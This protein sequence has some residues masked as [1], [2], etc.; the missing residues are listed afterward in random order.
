MLVCFTFAAKPGMEKEFEAALND[1]QMGRT[2]ARFL[3][4]TRNTLF[5]GHG[6][7]V[8]ILEFPDDH[9]VPSLADLAKEDP[10]FAAFMRRLGSL[11]QDGFDM[12]KPETLAAFNAR[13]GL[14]VVFDVR[15]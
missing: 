13:Y 3:G 5:V 7:M 15:P 6:R 11:V 12:D 1:P 14:P 4:A 2:V 10:R 8:R 9:K